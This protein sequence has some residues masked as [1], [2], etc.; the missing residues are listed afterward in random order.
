MIRLRTLLKQIGGFVKVD[1]TVVLLA[2]DQATPKHS[3]PALYSDLSK[4]MM[5]MDGETLTKELSSFLERKVLA[6]QGEV[7]ATSLEFTGM[8]PLGGDI[9]DSDDP[10]IKPE[11]AKY[12]GIWSITFP[13]GKITTI[14]DISMDSK[15]NW[16]IFNPT[17]GAITGTDKVGKIP[18]NNSD[19]KSTVKGV[20]E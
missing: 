7:S 18:D 13:N 9:N 4:G 14:D 8:V 11:E 3:F 1:G 19:K 17:K 20:T 12:N 16:F 5:K 2:C 6:S 10:Y 15:G